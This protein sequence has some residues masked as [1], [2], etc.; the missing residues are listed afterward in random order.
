M[1]PAL[2]STTAVLLLLLMPVVAFLYGR[3]RPLPPADFTFVLPKENATVDPAQAT[4]VSDQWVI[5]SL[6]EGLTRLD[7]ETLAP[8][9]AAAERWVVTDDGRRYRFHI[10]PQS[11]W[12]DGRPVTARDFEFAWRRVLSPETGCPFAFLLY[13]VVGAR[14]RNE[15]ESPG[16]LGIETEGAQ[17]L[18]VTLREPVPYFLSLVSHFALSPVP[19]ALV[20]RFGDGFAEAGR[21]IGNGAYRLELRRVRDRVRLVAQPH[22]RRYDSIE[23][24]VVDA[25]AIDEESTALNLYLTGRVDWVN[26]IPQTALPHLRGRPDLR[27]TPVLATNFL[28]FNVTRPPLAHVALRRAID[29]AID[30]E[31]LCRYVYRGAERPARSLVPPGLAGYELVEGPSAVDP[32]R[33]LREAGLDGPL[34]EL[35]LLHAADDDARAVAEAIAARLRDVLGLTVRPTPQEFRVFID[36]Q[37][38]LRYQICLTNW[39]GDYPDASN[40]LDLFRTGS[41]GNRTG[42]SEPRYDALLD[43]AAST[44]DPA[45]RIAAMREAEALLL[46]EGPIAPISYRGQANLVSDEID[47]FHDN[48]LDH[49]PLSELRRRP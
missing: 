11:R 46:A 28:R 3:P 10:D 16:S 29:L 36:S 6:F 21:L 7:P 1:N 9:P 25:L 39:I 13:G 2:R 8:R 35:E 42:W 18:T 45:A 5:Q 34:P 19:E 49:H 33:L 15:G 43:R 26:A 38:K 40:F 14:E 27:L 12:S 47:G 23:M 20:R 31:A 17:V 22:H 24:R 41:G 32:A 4:S 37:K 44:T 30:R 48:L